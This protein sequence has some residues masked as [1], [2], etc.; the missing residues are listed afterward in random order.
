[1]KIDNL[2]QTLSSG[3]SRVRR[4]TPVI[5]ILLSVSLIISLQP[6]CEL[7]VSPFLRHGIESNFSA[8]S[9]CPDHASTVPVHGKIDDQCG[10]GVST[11][12]ALT[13]AVPVISVKT[14]SSPVGALFI[15]AAS[16]EF[17]AVQRLLLS[18]AFHPSPPLFPIYL[19]FL[20]L[21]MWHPPGA[22][23]VR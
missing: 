10:P 13:Q 8:D 1:M 16:L 15:V 3:R 14:H 23:G 19:R 11:G 5:A 21:R 12:V 20:H 6:C 18:P 7:F 9:A 2:T 4:A 22:S 17:S